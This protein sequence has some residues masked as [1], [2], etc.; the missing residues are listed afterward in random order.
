[1]ALTTS[2]GKQR[3]EIITKCR[4]LWAQIE[5]KKKMVCKSSTWSISFLSVTYFSAHL[6]SHVQEKL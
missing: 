1:M 2:N 4:T 6:F 3:H 5:M